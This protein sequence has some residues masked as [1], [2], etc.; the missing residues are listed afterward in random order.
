MA[1]AGV[2]VSGLFFPFTIFLLINGSF[3]GACHDKGI[4][5]FTPFCIT[6]NF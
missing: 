4:T 2:V 3:L 6:V 5:V 1:K